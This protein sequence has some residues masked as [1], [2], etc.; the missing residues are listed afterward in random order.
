MCWIQTSAINPFL[1]NSHN[2]II[3]ISSLSTE[4][5][6]L[7]GEEGRLVL[8]RLST[9]ST[10]G[11]SELEVLVG[12][13]DV[14]VSLQILIG[15]NGSSDDLNGTITSTVS[16]SHLL[17]A[18]LDSTQKSHITVLLVHV[19][20]SRARIVTQPDSIVSHLHSRLVNLPRYQNQQKHQ[21]RSRQGSHRFRSSS[22]A[23]CAWSTNNGTWQSQGWERR[24]SFCRSRARGRSQ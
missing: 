5:A 7:L 18:L 4:S 13:H 9:V 14:L 15:N 2:A 1:P 22:S 6:G 12:V 24:V 19:V 8:L 21:P 20:G 3:L 23:V 16:S 11:Q 17:I 10:V